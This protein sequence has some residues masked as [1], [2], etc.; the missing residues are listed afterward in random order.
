MKDN[1][2]NIVLGTLATAILGLLGYVLLNLGEMQQQNAQQQALEFT[3]TDANK[4][5]DELTDIMNDVD[6]RLR[7]LERDIQWLRSSRNNLGFYGEALPSPDPPIEG[8]QPDP[9][10]PK[11]R[12]DIQSIP[13]R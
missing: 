4:L 11:P 3:I 13:E 5:H 10:P 6:M 2:W 1:I 7:L 8:E 12:Y 9:T